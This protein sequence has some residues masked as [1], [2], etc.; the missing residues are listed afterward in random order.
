M[1]SLVD[2]ISLLLLFFML[3]STFTRFAE[4]SPLMREST[5]PRSI[6]DRYSCNSQRIAPRCMGTGQ[7]WKIWASGSP[8]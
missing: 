1:N 7:P 8:S 3:T 2:V 4:V 6:A 5:S